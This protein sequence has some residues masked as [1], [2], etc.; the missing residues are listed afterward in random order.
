MAVTLSRVTHYIN[1]TY[2]NIPKARK[3]LGIQSVSLIRAHVARKLAEGESGQY[4]KRAERLAQSLERK[5]Q[6]KAQEARSRAVIVGQQIKSRRELKRLDVP[7]RL[8]AARDTKR[9]TAGDIIKEA[10][11]KGLTLQQ[12]K[13]LAMKRVPSI[14]PS[15]EIKKTIK[16]IDFKKKG[17]TTRSNLEKQVLEADLKE[18]KSKFDKGE[19]SKPVYIKIKKKQFSKPF[20][21]M[22]WFFTNLI[23]II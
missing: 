5:A 23:A 16:K 22:K 1:K 14:L 9:I 17:K 2:G 10:R 12:T 15:S 4:A 20:F 11:K 21:Y 18:I 7:V 13:D 6:Q 8:R 3:A 19:V